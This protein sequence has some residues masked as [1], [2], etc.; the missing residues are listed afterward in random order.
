MPSSISSPPFTIA[1]FIKSCVPVAFFSSNKPAFLGCHPGSIFSWVILNF[2]LHL[3]LLIPFWNTCLLW[4]PRHPSLLLLLLLLWLIFLA[5]LLISCLLML[6]ICFLQSSELPVLL[7]SP[8][9]F[10][11]DDSISTCG[12]YYHL[13]SDVSQLCSYHRSPTLQ[14]HFQLPSGH[15]QGIS[16]KMRILR[17]SESESRSVVFDSLWPHGLYSPWNSPGQNTQVGGLSLLQG[18]FP[19]QGP[20][21]GLLH[22]RWILYQL[23][24]MTFIESFLILWILPWLKLVN[25]I[26]TFSKFLHF[27][28]GTSKISSLFILTVIAPFKTTSPQYSNQ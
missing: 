16:Y 5:P 20:N 26:I 24:H 9:V 19:T 3:P 12:F 13:Y 4:V 23:N 18:I 27:V 1:S 28:Y 14:A 2:L 22:C 21:P 7:F 11:Q 10:S 15:H 8:S 17:M 25:Y 6:K